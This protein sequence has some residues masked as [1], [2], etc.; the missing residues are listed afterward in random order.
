MK[1]I[2]EDTSQGVMVSVYRCQM[3]TMYFDLV[4]CVQILTR[5]FWKGKFRESGG[6]W[7][8][9]FPTAFSASK[10]VKVKASP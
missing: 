3:N 5:G 2:K 1:K 8:N 10:T 6:V 4:C 7:G 9:K